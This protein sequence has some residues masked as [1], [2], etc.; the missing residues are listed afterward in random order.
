MDITNIMD[1]RRFIDTDIDTDRGLTIKEPVST[2]FEIA[3]ILYK[4]QDKT[5]F[6]ENVTGFDFRVIGNICHSRDSL[7]NAIGTSKSE[8]IGYVLNAIENP[9]D[10]TIIEDS[11]HA[12][13]YGRHKEIGSLFDLPVLK[14]FEKDGGRY[15]TAGIVIGKDREFGR[16]VSFHRMMVIDDNRMAIR[17]CRRHL[18]R[19]YK[20]AKRSG[21]PLE[22][23][24]SIGLHPVILYAAAYSLP[25]GY[26]EFS[27]ASSLTERLTGKPLELIKCQTVDLEVP[28]YSEI[29]I[30]GKIMPEPL[31]DEGPFV[32]ITGTYDIVRKQPV[33]EVSKI[34]HKIDP[35]YHAL[36]PSGAEHKIFMGMPQEPRIFRAVKK[37]AAVK[38][39]C[40]TE[41]GCNWLHGVVSI[42]KENEDDGKRAIRAALDGH[43]SM[44]HVIIVDDDIDI[45]NPTACEFAL[46]TRFQADRDAIMFENE[47]GSS[48]DPSAGE[49]SLTTKVGLDATKPLG[50]RGADFEPARFPD[51]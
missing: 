39:V 17:L 34:Y 1:I 44:K 20:R 50:R 26:D 43:P 12:G 14:H 35:I 24:V 42:K 40:L 51:S 49:G 46:A 11:E 27:L 38:N 19:Y 5:V 41:G 33:I 31:V 47:K 4:N 3:E 48:L 22:I 15:I 10:P 45:F 18:Y 13:R 37:E 7:C 25:L 21:K 32:D 29:I 36:L 6:F 2:D 23:A 16:N 9:T 8:Y 30:E 28:R